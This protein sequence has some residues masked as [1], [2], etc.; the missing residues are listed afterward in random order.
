MCIIYYC[1]SRIFQ[2]ML[3]NESL[4]LKEKKLAMFAQR[5]SHYQCIG[6]SG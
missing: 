1:E 6:E 5:I 2:D 4:P 3:N